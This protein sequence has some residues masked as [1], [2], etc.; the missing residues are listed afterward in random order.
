MKQT[1]ENV[2]ARAHCS[3]T[4]IRFIGIH[5]F[6]RQHMD[7]TIIS[8]ES[9][10]KFTRLIYVNERWKHQLFSTY[11][12]KEKREM[13]GK[14]DSSIPVTMFIYKCTL[15]IFIYYI[16]QPSAHDAPIS[17]SYIVVYFFDY[18]K[19]FFLLLL[20]QMI[21]LWACFK[22]TRS[23]YVRICACIELYNRTLGTARQ[24]L[25]VLTSFRFHTFQFLGQTDSK[26]ESDVQYQNAI[27]ILTLFCKYVIDMTSH[28]FF[29]HLLTITTNYM[30]QFHWINTNFI[31]VK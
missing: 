1:R 11:L 7:P 24:R 12:R 14:I 3:H 9:S 15:L 27:E 31:A 13:S 25:C 2:L 10:K 20:A 18:D 4:K 19:S 16:Y 29:R 26:W 23:P 22:Q 21:S 17:T 28:V 5:F 8:A 6:S 30:Y